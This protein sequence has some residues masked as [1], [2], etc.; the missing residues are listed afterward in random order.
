MPPATG[1]VVLLHIKLVPVAMAKVS[2]RNTNSLLDLLTGESIAV[3][4][5]LVPPVKVTVRINPALIIVPVVPQRS[6]VDQHVTLRQ[7]AP[8]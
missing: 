1:V 5:P 6:M 2:D 3:D 7:V 4:R 8:L